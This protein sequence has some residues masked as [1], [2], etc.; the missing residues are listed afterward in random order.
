VSQSEHRDAFR[1]VILPIGLILAL[2]AG[3]L[4]VCVAL[5]TKPRG[6]E[7]LTAVPPA[8][9][10]TALIVLFV[11]LVSWLAFQPFLDHFRLDRHSFALA[12]GVWIGSA[13]TQAIL[14]GLHIDSASPQSRRVSAGRNQLKQVFGLFAAVCSG[15]SS[16]KP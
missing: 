5:L 9:L 16:T 15:S 12:L 10:S 6:F 2:I 7:A 1:R 11:Y 14:V 3:S 13:F 8:I 4:D